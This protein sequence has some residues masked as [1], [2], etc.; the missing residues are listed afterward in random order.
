MDSND[1]E[2]LSIE[3]IILPI[4][5]L[6]LLYMKS[7]LLF[8]TQKRFA[9]WSNKNITSQVFFSIRK[10]LRAH[11]GWK[12]LYCI[13]RFS[14]EKR[15]EPRKPSM[16]E[17]FNPNVEFWFRIKINACLKLKKQQISFKNGV[18]NISLIFY[19]ISSSSCS[20][21]WNTFWVF[22]NYKTDIETN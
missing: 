6:V 5:P 2:Y 13:T 10:D 17:E 14:M 4:H 22:F 9:F 3:H 11:F 12:R 7:I 19:D 8:L 21:S 20:L 16:F 1:F 18:S 15:K